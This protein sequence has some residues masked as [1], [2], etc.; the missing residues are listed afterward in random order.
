MILT[1]PANRSTSK[2]PTLGPNLYIYG[3]FDPPLSL[4]AH[5]LRS[6]FPYTVIPPLHSL[7]HYSILF[8][9]SLNTVSIYFYLYISSKP[10]ITSL[11]SLLETCHY[12][13]LTSTLDLT[14]YYLSLLTLS[15]LFFIRSL[16]I[17]PIT[18][19]LLTLSSFLHFLHSASIISNQPPHLYLIQSSLSVSSLSLSDFYEFDPLLF[20]YFVMISCLSLAQLTQF[21][22]VF[23]SSVLSTFP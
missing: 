4:L 1:P 5:K 9:L 18:H 19:Y 10:C 14:L 22:S 6:C 7:S 3:R 2:I 8:Y 17:Y 20:L 21:S 12:I 11:L 23:H 13:L 16:S 15:Y